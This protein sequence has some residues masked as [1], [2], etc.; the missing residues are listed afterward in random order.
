[1]R[2]PALL[3]SF[4]V[5]FLS[6][7]AETLW[8]RTYA[9]GNESTPH[10]L[11][12]VLA[13]YLLGIARGAAI[14]GDKCRTSDRI[15]DVATV[16]ILAASTV[17]MASPL[18]I[19]LLPFTS[20]V[21]AVLIFLPAMLFS[22]CFPICHHLG[23]VAG[24]GKTGRSLSRVYASNIAGSMCGPLAIN[25]GLLE[26]ATTQ[27]AF[28]VLGAAGIGLAA[29][30]ASR[31]APDE[32]R[33]TPRATPL[34]KISL[35]AGTVAVVA[36]ILAPMSANHLIGRLASLHAP[37]RHIVETRQGIVVAHADDAKGDVIYG[38]NVYDGRTN[39]D[40][41]VNSNG[42][43]RII[44]LAALHPKPKRVLMLGLSVGSWQH[45]VNG[46]PGVERVD[47]LEIN[48]G[49]LELARHY[50]AQQRAVADPRV[51]VI[52]GDGRKYL[53]QHPETTYD[54]V[55]MNTTWHWRMYSALLL[56]QEFLT[57]L[58]KHMT[59]D[60]FLA[61]N[62]T[63]SG[64]ALKTA[65]TV[66]PHAYAYESFVVAGATDWRQKLAAPGAQ[67]ALRNIKPGGVPLFGPG[68]SDVIRQFLSPALSK[69][70]DEVAQSVGRPLEVITDRNLITEYRYGRQSIWP[71]IWPS[72]LARR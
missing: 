23:T 27:T 34:S 70:L 67:A 9:F 6:L 38:G 66:F 7:G 37:I 47:V 56:S 33:D 57:V 62:T 63:G 21:L 71:S 61:F 11:A 55:I 41:R 18:L 10:A 5:G 4:F 51:N 36:L 22:I 64:D 14:G 29:V 35:A 50:E 16:S 1:M 54:L 60:A 3:I 32:R 43:N 65:A 46:F 26:F 53:R 24:T 17:L 69:D 20:V 58:R 15:V 13:L 31:N 52:I 19:V 68:D 28:V 12:V 42:L 40:P 72:I 45:I 2:F 25:F 44:M 59:P 39:L 48:P 8:V 49:Y 30:L